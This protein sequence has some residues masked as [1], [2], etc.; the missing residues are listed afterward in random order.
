MVIINYHDHVYIL[1]KNALAIV[2]TITTMKKIWTTEATERNNNC[3]T[4]V[5]PIANNPF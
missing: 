2:V 1:K 3:F 5:S 4:A